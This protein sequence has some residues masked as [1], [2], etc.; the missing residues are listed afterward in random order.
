MS[1]SNDDFDQQY[2][3]G[4]LPEGFGRPDENRVYWANVEFTYEKGSAHHGIF[5]GG[6][7]YGFARA[8][9]VRDALDKI[10]KEF[11]DRKLG[12]R[13][14]DYVTEYNEVPWE[15]EEDQLHFDGVAALT[16]STGEVFLDSFEVYE[17]R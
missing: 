5:E 11:E 3:D 12:V 1:S 16:G 7:V 6:I 17:R 15:T 9:D 13:V 2:P 8:Y 4:Q 14:V 10:V